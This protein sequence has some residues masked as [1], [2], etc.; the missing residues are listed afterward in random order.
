MLEEMLRDHCTF[1]L[2][3]TKQLP[4][5]AVR[6]IQ[7]DK[8]DLVV[9]AAMPPGGIPQVRYMCKEIRQV[10][11]DM[12]IIVVCFAELTNYDEMLVSLR[13]SG[14]SY[15]TTS[16]GQTKLQI[17]K[18]LEELMQSETAHEPAISATTTP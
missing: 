15:L 13:T 12:T 2:A 9:L 11:P 17:E 8:P 16:L 5:K 10:C 14:A 6:Q 3:T 7:L 4:S 1:N 18:M